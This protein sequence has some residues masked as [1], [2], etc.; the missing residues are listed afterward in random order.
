MR[1]GRC[2]VP[3]GWKTPSCLRANEYD[4]ICRARDG[5]ACW[6]HTSWQAKRLAARIH[7][8]APLAH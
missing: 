5:E 6:P 2:A 3:A 1:S 8:L 4:R 7:Y